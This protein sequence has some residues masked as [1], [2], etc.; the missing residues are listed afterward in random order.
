MCKKVWQWATSCLSLS[1][2]CGQNSACISYISHM[3]TYLWR[4]ISLLFIRYITSGNT[5]YVYIQQSISTTD[6]LWQQKI[7]IC[8]KWTLK[9]RDAKR[10]M[11]L[12]DT[13]Y[14]PDCRTSFPLLII[15]AQLRW[16]Y[17]HIAQLAL[18]STVSS[19][20][21]ENINHAKQ[22][23]RSSLWKSH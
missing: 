7:P 16:Q 13:L 1:K 15:W 5:I 10:A 17:G 9:Q 23:I 14:T 20:T 6:Q 11:L 4:V 2:F 19:D 22:V 18:I 3:C 12:L 8:N 21:I